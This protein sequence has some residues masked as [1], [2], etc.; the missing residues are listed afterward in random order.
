M[1]VAMQIPS[2]TALMPTR[3]PAGTPEISTR[4]QV[5]AEGREQ[6]IRASL[7]LVLPAGLL[8]IAEDGLRGRFADER[9]VRVALDDPFGARPA[10][11]SSGTAFGPGPVVH[12]PD[13]VPG[14]GQRVHSVPTS[15]VTGQVIPSWCAASVRDT[16]SPRRFEVVS[17]APIGCEIAPARKQGLRAFRASMRP[18]SLCE[19][20]EAATWTSA[21]WG[22]EPN[23]KVARNSQA[24]MSIKTRSNSAIGRTSSNSRTTRT[25]RSIAVR[26]KGRRPR[27]IS[28]PTRKARTRVIV[29]RTT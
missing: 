17:D 16:P 29:V 11:A 5:G 25:R 14:I 7:A 19:P 28:A 4:L 2:S 3:W 15:N 26:I 23:N 1:K 6:V 12:T 10:L 18:G 20:R 27:V 21:T 8:G 22:T 24:A 13:R 9:V